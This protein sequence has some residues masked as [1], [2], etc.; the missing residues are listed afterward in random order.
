MYYSGFHLDMY[1]TE[2]VS[3]N[4]QNYMFFKFI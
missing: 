4:I 2:E 1:A 3:V